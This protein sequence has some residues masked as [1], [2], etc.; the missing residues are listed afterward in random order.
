MIS[1]YNVKIRNLNVDRVNVFVKYLND[2]KHKN[3]SKH[4]TSIYNLSD[5]D[6]FIQK[7]N[8]KIEMNK[9]AF[10]KRAR[11]G[12]RLKVFGKSLTF[13]IP[14]SFIVNELICIKVYNDL[15]TQIID[16]YSQY[17]YEINESDF[18]SVLHLQSNA[19]FHIV[20]PYL[21]NHGNTLKYTTRKHFLN[22]LKLIW[23]NTVENHF[24]VSKEDYIPL[25]NAEEGN[26]K[27]IRY[28]QELL[29]FYS[30]LEES[31]YIKN[32]MVVINRLLNENSEINQDK[33]QRIDKNKSKVVKNLKQN[34]KN[35]GKVPKL[36]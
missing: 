3:H 14:K 32:Q 5:T 30:K 2:A 23:T 13:N 27:T 12:R 10:I 28:L 6:L 34:N 36:N 16:L 15:I 33:L 31:K 9:Q 20:L 17:N 35:F 22:E 26:N 8:D 25:S 7:S 19:H 1:N 18:Y 4:N 21:D 11:G 24:K 29:S